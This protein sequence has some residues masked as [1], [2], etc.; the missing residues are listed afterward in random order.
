MFMKSFS[1]WTIEEVEEQFELCQL[2]DS[3][4]LADW[5][6]D[7]S[8]L[9]PVIQSQLEHLQQKLLQRV[10]DWNEQELLVYFIGP[11]LTLVDFEHE[12]F[13][14]FM[15]RELSV[16]LDGE[17]LSGVVD[18]LVAQGHRSPKQ[19]YFFLHEYKREQDSSNDPLGQLMIAM[20]TAQLLNNDDQP[21]YGAYVIG[22]YWH[23]VLLT[24]K[25]YAVHVGLNALKPELTQIWA[26]LTHTKTL[27]E[28]R[29]LHA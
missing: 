11:L 3:P 18:F 12:L 14:P 28:Q 9:S 17:R 20:V 10:Y 21:L 7:R 13:H 23:F 8:P 1:Q 19:P 27:I 25:T 5:M 2:R 6:A 4:L 29:L 24:G 26:I 15:E 16:I 22:R